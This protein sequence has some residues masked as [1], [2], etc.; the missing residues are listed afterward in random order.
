MEKRLHLY[1]LSSL[2]KVFL[3]RIYGDAFSS[4][5]LLRNEEY[6]FQIAYMLEGS[7]VKRRYQVSVDSPLAD[8]ITIRRVVNVPSEMPSFP[9]TDGN[10]ITKEPGLFPDPLIPLNGKELETA[11]GLFHSLWVTVKPNGK[12]PPGEYP[13]SVTLT[14]EEDG[15]VVSATITLTVINA[16]LPEQTLIHTQWF[17]TDSIASYYNLEIFSPAHWNWIEKF[18]QTAVA[19]GINMILTPIFTPPLDTRPGGERPTVQLVDVFVEQGVYRFGFERLKHWVDLARRVGYRYFEISHLF[20]QWGAEHSPKI[21]VNVDGEYQRIFGWETEA[22]SEEYSRFLHTFLPALS[23]FLKKEGIWG[24][25]FFHVSDEPHSHQLESYRRASQLLRDC[26][27]DCRSIDALSEYEFY[28]Q[29]LVQTPVPCLEA[30]QEF[31]DHGVDPLWTYYCCSEGNEVSNRFFA[32]PSA[33]NRILGI[34]LFKYNITGFL[35]WGYNFYYSQL[36]TEKINPW[37]TTDAGNAFPSGDAFCVY[38]GEDQ[39]IESIGLKVFHEGLQ[40]LRALQLLEKKIGRSGVIQL[41]EDGIEPITMFRYP[42]EEQYLLKLRERVNRL[43]DG[44]GY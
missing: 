37:L 1:P 19:N 33:R 42:R 27:P 7:L 17:H 40:D 28:E 26:L 3:H 12:I 43:L 23:D 8:C 25:S 10:Y 22:A 9:G 16:L 20:T 24:N 38:P 2:A 11:P 15:A 36:C 35:Q 29:G 44:E 41:L 14:D 4:G 6:S 5:S 30:L 13:V 39:V 31:F 32:M 18:M 21:M 34:Q